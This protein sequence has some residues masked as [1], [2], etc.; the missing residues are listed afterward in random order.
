MVEDSSTCPN[1]P[2]RLSEP[3]GCYFPT[4]T[5]VRYGQETKTSSGQGPG[6]RKTLRLLAETL[7]YQGET[8]LAF[9]PASLIVDDETEVS[10]V[11]ITGILSHPWKPHCPMESPRQAMG[12]V[13]TRDKCV[14]CRVTETGEARG[15]LAKSI[16]SES[17]SSLNEHIAWQTVMIYAHFII[18]IKV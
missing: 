7:A 1:L 10:Q 9:F 3:G 8:F 15:S 12:F 2:P 6:N 11:Q 14:L 5:A 13:Q 16:L 17:R 4:Y 18:V